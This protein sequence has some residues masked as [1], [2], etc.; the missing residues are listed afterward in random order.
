M[1]A[2]AAQRLPAAACAVHAP[3]RALC[4]ASNPVFSLARSEERI[5]PPSHTNRRS[6]A[7][8]VPVRDNPDDVPLWTE[9]IGSSSTRF[10]YDS[11]LAS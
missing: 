1:R 7:R 4:T 9:G 8:P 6:V 5:R 2:A 11:D 3:H 10:I